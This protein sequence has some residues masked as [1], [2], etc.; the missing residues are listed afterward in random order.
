VHDYQEKTAAIQKIAANQQDNRNAFSA[1]NLQPGL[2]ALVVEAMN[3]AFKADL[4]PVFASK[5]N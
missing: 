4:A 1:A 3:E 5:A 2:S